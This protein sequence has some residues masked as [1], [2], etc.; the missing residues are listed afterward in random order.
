MLKNILDYETV[1][2]D[3]E[4]GELVIIDQTKL[5]TNIEIIR[6]KTAKEIWDAIYLLKVRGAPAIGVAAAMGLYVLA[7]EHKDDDSVTFFEKLGKYRDYLRTGRG[8]KDYDSARVSLH[9]R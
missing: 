3:V 2:L 6:L 8:Y 5:P 4:S 9:H 1:D 7:L